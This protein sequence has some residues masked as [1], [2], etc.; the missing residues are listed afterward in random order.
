MDYED[1]YDYDCT[2]YVYVVFSRS[3]DDY[4]P[5]SVDAIFSTEEGA[6]TYINNQYT[7]ELYYSVPWEVM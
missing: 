5:D 6:E 7:P 1:E 4:C 2:D 3:D